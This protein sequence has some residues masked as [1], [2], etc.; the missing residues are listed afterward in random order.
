MNKLCYQTVPKNKINFRQSFSQTIFCRWEN[1][2]ALSAW[3]AEEQ[4]PE[5]IHRLGIE[6]GGRDRRAKNNSPIW[7]KLAIAAGGGK[8]NVVGSGSPN[9]QT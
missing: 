2:F 1:H 8:S 4:G 6:W 3:R 9:S 7:A 5:K